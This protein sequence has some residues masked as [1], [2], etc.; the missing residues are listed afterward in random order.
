MFISF[1]GLWMVQILSLPD[2]IR[3]VVLQLYISSGKNWNSKTQEVGYFYFSKLLR[4]DGLKKQI[5]KLSIMI[6]IVFVLLLVTLVVL[7]N[8]FL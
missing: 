3:T 5:N 2:T 7:I 4:M 1:R 8:S 6:G